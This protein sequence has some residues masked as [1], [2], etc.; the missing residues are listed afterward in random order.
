MWLSLLFRSAVRGSW[1]LCHRGPHNAQFV[2]PGTNHLEIDQ[3]TQRLRA[4]EEDGQ[5][6][7]EALVSAE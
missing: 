6:A 5:L 3:L 4:Y 2:T 1:F 7:F